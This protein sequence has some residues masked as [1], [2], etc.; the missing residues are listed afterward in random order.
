MAVF[1]SFVKK[2]AL[3]K[4]HDKYQK[5]LQK[6]QL[7]VK[8]KIAYFKQFR[9]KAAHQVLNSIFTILVISLL[10]RKDPNHISHWYH[11]L[12]SVASYCNCMGLIPIQFLK[13][14]TIFTISEF[15]TIC[16]GMANKY[17]V[18]LK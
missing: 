12:S 6:N 2:K 10:V 11:K 9:Q 5:I 1:C 16:R 13:S 4:F 15:W 14:N 7:Y 17:M 18:W 8:Y 3:S